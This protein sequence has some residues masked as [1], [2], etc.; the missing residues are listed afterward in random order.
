MNK[1]I[2]SE[3]LSHLNFLTTLTADSI[4]DWDYNFFI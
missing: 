3:S 4:I 2:Y 1:R